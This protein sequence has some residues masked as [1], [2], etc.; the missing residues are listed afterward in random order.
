MAD[1]VLIFRQ[2]LAS[3]P[4]TI[5]DESARAI[6]RR[7]P[8]AL[9]HPGARLRRARGGRRP[10]RRHDRAGVSARQA[11]GAAA[12]GGRRRRHDRR[13]PQVPRIPRRSPSC[14]CHPPSR[15]P[16]R[17]PATTACTSRPA[18]SSPSTT[19]RT[20]R[21]RCSCAAWSPHFATLPDDI[22]CVQAKLVYHNGH[23]NLLTAWFTAEYGLWFGYL[24]PG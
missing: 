17:R 8:A 18:R 6:P 1:R 5:T 12:A 24:L 14:W 11:A 16:S 15:G 9:H 10:D 7:G 20:C 13:R 19:P 22:A 3:R 21:N 4:I 23:Q 2:G